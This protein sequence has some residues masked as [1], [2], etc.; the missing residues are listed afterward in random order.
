MTSLLGRICFAPDLIFMLIYRVYDCF[1]LCM[2]HASPFFQSLSGTD[3]RDSYTTSVNCTQ[4]AVHYAGAADPLCGFSMPF[5]SS[6]PQSYYLSFDDFTAHYHLYQ[7]W[8]GRMWNVNEW[9]WL[10]KFILR[11]RREIKKKYELKLSLGFFWWFHL[12]ILISVTVML[13]EFQNQKHSLSCHSPFFWNRGGR[14][15]M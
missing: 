12:A 6:P 2:A 10:L 13:I 9:K 5:I 7:K 15:E 14:G 8:E 4:L 11:I 3:S 1:I